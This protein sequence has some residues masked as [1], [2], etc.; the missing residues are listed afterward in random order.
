MLI[1]PSVNALTLEEKLEIQ[2]SSESGYYILNNTILT[3]DNLNVNSTYADFINLN[4]KNRTAV[5]V[6]TSTGKYLEI[7][8]KQKQNCSLPQTNSVKNIL[9]R[10][11]TSTE[12]TDYG[13]KSGCESADCKW[14]SPISECML[15]TESCGP[16][17]HPSP[18][19]PPPLVILPNITLPEVIIKEVEEPIVIPWLMF[20]LLG[21]SWHDRRK[22]KKNMNQ[23]KKE[24]S[25]EVKKNKIKRRPNSPKMV[26]L[27]KIFKEQKNRYEFATLTLIISAIVLGW[28]AKS[29]III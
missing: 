22:R 11:F 3:I 17:P 4:E 2:P 10:N 23:L 6:N 29:W 9:F 18:I 27:I 7:I 28:V 1:I 12:C 16:G 25:K 19:I 14:C 15:T 20:G 13:A 24:I 8:C 5:V 21:Y 26:R